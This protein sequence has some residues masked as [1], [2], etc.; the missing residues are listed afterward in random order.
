[1]A[2]KILV[3]ITGANTGL[4]EQEPPSLLLQYLWAHIRQLHTDQFNYILGL[5]IAKALFSRPDAYHIL[6]GCRGDISRATDAIS[7]L[8][9]VSPKSHSTAEP[10]SVDITSDE[11]ITTAYE[12]V[13]RK[14]GYV[15]VVVNNA[16]GFF[17]DFYS[18]IDL[19]C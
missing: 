2:S 3:L 8:Q 7:K 9:Q 15:D 11:S 4:G 19:Q 16:G 18:S 6:I 14:F 13:K 5:E 1:M 10:L 12:E 17:R